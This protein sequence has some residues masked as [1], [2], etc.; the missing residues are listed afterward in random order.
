[1]D[2]HA[3]MRAQEYR[4]RLFSLHKKGDLPARDVAGQQGRSIR[5]EQPTAVARESQNTTRALREIL[6]QAPGYSDRKLTWSGNAGGAGRE[7]GR[8]DVS[9]SPAA[10]LGRE[11]VR[12]RALCSACSTLNTPMTPHFS[13]YSSRPT[14]LSLRRAACVCMDTGRAARASQ[15]TSSDAKHFTRA[16]PQH[17]IRATRR[18][19]APPPRAAPEQWMMSRG[20]SLPDRSTWRRG[21]AL[22]PCAACRNDGS[23]E[24]PR[25]KASSREASQGKACSKDESAVLQT[26]GRPCQAPLL[27]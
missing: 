17:G 12:A 18:R 13:L 6:G 11:R 26:M 25:G 10:V 27:D 23:R 8:R 1:M 14:S 3:R 19:H 21:R 4:H 16:E 7:Q 24:W 22:A 9:Q 5:H 15:V 2:T 20:R